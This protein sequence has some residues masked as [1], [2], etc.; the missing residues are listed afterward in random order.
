MDSFAYTG[1]LMHNRLKP[2]K[3]RFAYRVTSWLFDLAEL[4]DLHKRQRLFSRNRF[5]V[6]SFYDNDYGNGS[7]VALQEQ[8]TELLN[9]HNI[10]APHTIKLLCYPRIFGHTF[11][12]LAVYYCYRDNQLSAI[13]YEVSNTFRERHA[14]VAKIDSNENNEP[15]MPV[16]GSFITRQK[17]NKE[18]HVSPFFPMDCHY[19]FRVT[20]PQEK[21][22][23]G[24]TLNNVQ[25]RLFTAVFSGIRH[26]ISDRF[27]LKQT[28][29][30]PLQAFKVI[31]AIHWEA[32]RLWLKGIG[33]YKHRARGHFFSHS[34]ATRD[35]KI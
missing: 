13:V 11:N 3:H 32:L 23:L 14:Y 30:L 9:E 22:T 24:I 15:A 20:P 21:V 26:K 35:N 7:S 8:I 12:P 29:L 1:Q 19:H 2:K 5:N 10:E 4:D 33:I 17:A 6:V 16:S 18:L 31:A 28:L 27:I 25:G 34:R